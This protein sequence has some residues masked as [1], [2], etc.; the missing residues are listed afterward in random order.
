M[1]EGRQ[2]NLLC[3]CVSVGLIGI[4]STR[5][6]FGVFGGSTLSV[7]AWK[8]NPERM[9]VVFL[10]VWWDKLRLSPVFFSW[11]VFHLTLTTFV[12]CAETT[13]SLTLVELDS[14]Q[15]FLSVNQIINFTIIFLRELKADCCGH[16]TDR[17]PNVGSVWCRWRKLLQVLSVFLERGSWT[18]QA[19]LPSSL[20]ECVTEKQQCKV[21]LVPIR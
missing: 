11:C 18:V 2:S 10:T 1:N 12:S 5:G 17:R 14:I 21:L 15:M 9:W 20:C 8:E 19:A 13:H 6:L 4:K 3:V 16:T 7:S